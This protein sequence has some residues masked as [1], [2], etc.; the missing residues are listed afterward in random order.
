MHY[1]KNIEVNQSA[2]KKKKTET[3]LVSAG[4]VIGDAFR[5]RRERRE[6]KEKRM[7][8]SVTVGDAKSGRPKKEPKL[9]EAGFII[10]SN[11][12]IIE[13]DYVMKSTTLN[14]KMK[15]I[16]KIYLKSKMFRR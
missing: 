7:I 13:K 3:K 12:P 6:F 10:P 11:R 5:R 9:D 8:E 16:K 14:L 15:Q 1:T 4:N 2:Y